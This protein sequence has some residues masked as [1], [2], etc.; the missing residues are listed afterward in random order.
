MALS[1]TPYTF[2]ILFI[3]HPVLTALFLGFIRSVSAVILSVTF[4]ARRD[5]SSRVLAAEL[6]H[7]ACHL[8]CAI[9]RGFNG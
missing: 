3:Y 9:E 4:P 6:I 5:A 7:A 2:F 8:S 1:L